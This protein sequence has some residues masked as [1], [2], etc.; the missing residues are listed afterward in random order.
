[1]SLTLHVVVGG[2]QRVDAV[3]EGRGRSWAAALGGEGRHAW[4][5]DEPGLEDAAGHRGV[6]V[7]GTHEQAGQQVEAR[8]LPEVADH[9]GAALADL[10]Q[11]GLGHPLQGLADR[12]PGDAE[13]L[14]QS[15]L[16]GQGL[17]GLDLAVDDPGE[18][19]VED[20]VGDRPA[21]DGL[22]GHAAG[23]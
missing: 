10:H 17:A 23:P 21:T 7:A 3:G 12:R 15:T 20:I 1:M 4:S 6:E 11:P 14:G 16:A 22:Q 9:R 18:D 8:G 13:H 2:G 5:D 19:L